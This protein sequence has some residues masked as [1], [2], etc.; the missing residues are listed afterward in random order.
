MPVDE[1]LDVKRHRLPRIE[2]IITDLRNNNQWKSVK[3]VL[4]SVHGHPRYGC[5]GTQ[6]TTD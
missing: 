5:K 2:M 3:S 1:A 4:I 6:I